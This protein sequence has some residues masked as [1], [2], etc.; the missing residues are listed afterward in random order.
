LSEF[1][2]DVLALIIGT[3]LVMLVWLSIEGGAYRIL[4]PDTR[5][6]SRGGDSQPVPAIVSLDPE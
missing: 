1:F 4:S 3:V 2:K 5:M 6:D